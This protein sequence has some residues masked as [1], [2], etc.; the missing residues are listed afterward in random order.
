M[1]RVQSAGRGQTGTGASAFVSLEGL[2]KAATSPALVT[3]LCLAALLRIWLV[4]GQLPA[5]IHHL[6]FSI[7][8][9]SALALHENLN[10]YRTN[11]GQFGRKLGLDTSTIDRATDP[12]TF[13]LCWEPLTLMSVR[14][15]YWTWI[16]LNF[17]ALVLAFY[18]LLGRR[19][20]LGTRGILALA[21]L[22]ILYPPVAV[23]FILAQSKILLLLLL[24]L[25]IRWMESEHDA[26]AGLTLALAGLLRVYP[27]LILGY[28][29]L[30]RRWRVLEYS[31]VGL[32]IGG[33]L[34]F[35]F[36]GIAPTMSFVFDA[37]EF[38][39]SG[40]WVPFPAD[41][42][43]RAF[44][45]R[46]FWIYGT[47]P[48]V[49]AFDSI[50]RILVV[51]AQVGVLAITVKA[52]LAATNHRD[53]D[54]RVFSL[55]VV[56][57]VMLSPVSYLHDMV[58]VLILLAGLVFAAGRGAASRRALWMA[59]VSCFLPGLLGYAA[60]I[61][62]RLQ[63]FSY[64]VPLI[65]VEASRRLFMG[66]QEYA[67]FSLLLAYLSAYWFVTDWA[68]K[69]TLKAEELPGRVSARVQSE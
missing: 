17:L 22:T 5:K 26:I 32:A 46:Q 33:M 53:E 18:L 30:R 66:F 55:W 43:L 59:I 60:V 3:L 8:Y 40:Q 1:D 34:T 69:R 24:V 2:G 16:G 23:N 67:F 7:Y 49:F 10:P 28:V 68:A 62:E 64:A 39:N 14:H 47:K 48:P 4:F 12:P 6:D 9:S 29:V 57:A 11:I 56:S 15:T 13:L 27:L 63:L 31:L 58:L 51:L 61:L 19:P 21:A 45:S 25:T 41:L 50:R 44:V 52:T 20:A 36:V 65:G 42:S 54:W 37:I 35:A 38:L